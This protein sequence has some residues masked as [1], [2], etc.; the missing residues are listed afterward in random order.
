MTKLINAILFA[1]LVSLS[2]GQAT[3]L[4]QYSFSPQFVDNDDVY[5]LLG[6]TWSFDILITQP[7][8]TGTSSPRAFA[9]EVWLTVTDSSVPANNGSFLLTDIED[10]AF[11]V[12]PQRSNWGQMG[13]GNPGI[14]SPG[15]MSFGGMT[16]VEFYLNTKQ[17]GDIPSISIGDPVQASDFD[18]LLSGQVFH[19]LTTDEYAAHYDG[20]AG[21]FQATNV[22]EAGTWAALMGMAVF[23]L[24]IGAS[25][26]RADKTDK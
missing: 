21:T 22:P 18:N 3:V 19:T 20:A 7:T 25:V 23:A 13:I 2:T 14:F 1:L 9:D 10:I 4:L 26:R 15:E 16:S 6:S 5:G 8:Y 24:A 11:V 17:S 12:K